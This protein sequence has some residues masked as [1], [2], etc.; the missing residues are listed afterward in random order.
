MKK[1]ILIGYMASGKSTI[2]KLFAK[3]SNIEFEDLDLYIEKKLETSIETIFKTKGEIY[4]RKIENHYLVELLASNEK[5]VVS[6]GG[7]TPCFTNNNEILF[8]DNYTTVYLK[9]SINEL[10]NRLE[11]NKDKRPLLA[12]LNSEKMREYIGIH[13]FERSVFYN[14]ATYT[15]NIDGKSPE[16]IVSEIKDLL[17]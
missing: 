14:K 7:G 13:L 16:E 4:F 6:L 2:G 3:S 5:M 10:Y 9:A 12:N 11:K 1:I 15:I 8:T 17:F